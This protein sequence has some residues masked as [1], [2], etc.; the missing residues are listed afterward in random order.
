MK[1]L[2]V[3]A[4]AV[5]LAAPVFAGELFE[6][7]GERVEGEYICHFV[8]NVN[9]RGMGMELGKQRGVDTMGTF[10]ALNS[11][12]FRMNEK[13]ARTLAQNPNIKY[14]EPNLIARV[15]G[16]Q[17]NPPWGVDRVDQRNLPLSN[18]YHWD[19]D[20]SNVDAWVLDT[21]VRTTHN[22]FGGRASSGYVN[23]NG[24]GQT[25]GHGHGSHVAGS[26][27]G[28]TY[29]VAKNVNIKS[30]K[31]CSD[32]GSCPS[33]ATSCGLNYVANNAS[34]D[35]VGNFSI[36]GGFSQSSNDNM[37][38]PI[39]A[40]VFF[41]VAAGNAG[42]DACNYSPASE[43]TA[44]TVGCSRSN[45]TSCGY[46]DGS[47]VD[48]IAPGYQILSSWYT[49]NSATATISGTSMS[50][51]HVAG[52]AALVLQENPGMTPAQVDAEL[53]ARATTGALNMGQA[54]A[55]AGEGVEARR[56]LPTSPS[57]DRAKAWSRPQTAPPWAGSRSRKR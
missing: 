23:C 45:D 34:G 55:R 20:G 27:G 53:D 52:A 18:S 33:N 12:H 4:L 56:F 49:G 35:S 48:I 29:G 54:P 16:D 39:A 36:G 47:C 3:I 17:S 9:A 13:T 26:V 21:G 14:C 51:P 25:D 57:G 5:L 41:A 42:G 30:I 50:S 24:Y 19:Y 8:D 37:A 46:N 2:V 11:A 10:N 1:K 28:A 43:P 38:V 6:R 15:D 44:Y 31:V 22:D 7:A 40:G 32:G